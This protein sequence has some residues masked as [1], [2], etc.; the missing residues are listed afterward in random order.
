M[1]EQRATSIRS[2][3]VSGCLAVILGFVAVA[4]V[5]GTLMSPKAPQRIAQRAE[6]VTIDSGVE[7][8]YTAE[9]YEK[10]FLVWGD[11]GMARIERTRKGAAQIA[12]RSFEC[13]HVELSELS[14]Q[15]SVYPDTI[16]VF[17]DC[18]N[19]KRFY[20]SEAEVIAAGY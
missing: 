10:F 8:P 13:D 15:R 18:T 2:G 5:V 1:T 3:L 19:R 9:A 14:Q 20:V 7:T 11:D 16:I 6:P 12:A 17:V 4:I